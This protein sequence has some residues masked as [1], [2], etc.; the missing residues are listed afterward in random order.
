MKL[1]E[2]R[3]KAE[4]KAAA[5]GPEAV[6]ELTEMREEFAAS[7]K[8]ALS[9]KAQKAL[10]AVVTAIKKNDPPMSIERVQ[11]QLKS[12][13]AFISSMLGPDATDDQ[14]AAAFDACKTLEAN[15]ERITKLAREE[16]L[17]RL[18]AHGHQEGHTLQLEKDGWVLRAN[19]THTGLDPKKVEARLREQQ[20]DPA[21]YMTPTISYKLNPAKS[22]EL[23]QVLAKADCLVDCLYDERWQV[24]APEQL[25]T[26][27]DSEGRLMSASGSNA[28]E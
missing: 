5:A 1:K 27:T 20:I 15:A 6:K 16:V 22:D 17:G 19:R 28:L 13:V 2:L 7:T 24:L 26:Y 23:D 11:S 14:V 3:K 8:K 4:K 21:L 25:D 18:K 9:P 10:A 12:V